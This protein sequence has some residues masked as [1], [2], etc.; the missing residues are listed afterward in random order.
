M[1]VYVC[2][3]CVFKRSPYTHTLKR[4]ALGTGREGR[5]D[6]REREE[7]REGEREGKKEVDNDCLSATFLYNSRYECLTESV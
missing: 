2:F 4:L 5:S 3:V 1:C 6:A 7:R